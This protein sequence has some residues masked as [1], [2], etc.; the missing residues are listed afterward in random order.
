MGEWGGCSACVDVW[1][2]YLSSI[3]HKA[4]LILSLQALYIVPLKKTI[5]CRAGEICDDNPQIDVSLTARCM[6]V[7]RTTGVKLKHARRG[8]CACRKYLGDECSKVGLRSCSRATL[9]T[10]SMSRRSSCASAY[11]VV[12]SS[13]RSTNFEL[14]VQSTGRFICRMHRRCTTL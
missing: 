5:N 2:T 9:D 7:V 12:S 3:W 13:C 10:S 6:W 4:L 8:T 11:G 14:H 1:T